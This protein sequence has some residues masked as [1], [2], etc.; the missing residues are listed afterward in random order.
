MIPQR[1]AI[2]NQKQDDDDSLVQNM[3]NKMKISE[4]TTATVASD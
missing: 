1:H 3:E 2:N 4:A